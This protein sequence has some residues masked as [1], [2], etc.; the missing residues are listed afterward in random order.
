M[1]R[2]DWVSFSEKAGQFFKN[3]C[4]YVALLLIVVR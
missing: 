2:Q 4:V 3:R 1:N